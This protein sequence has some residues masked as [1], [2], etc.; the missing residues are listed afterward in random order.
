MGVKW[1]YILLFIDME[2]ACGSGRRAVL[3]NILIELG[4]PVKLV[5]AIKMCLNETDSKIS[6]GKLLSVAFPI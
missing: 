6:T 1:D 3:Y 4:M 5:G 2:V